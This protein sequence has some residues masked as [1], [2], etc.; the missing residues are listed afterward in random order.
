[1]FSYRIQNLSDC[2]HIIFTYT[3]IYKCIPMYT[4]VRFESFTTFV[5]EQLNVLFEPECKILFSVN[6]NGRK[7]KTHVIYPFVM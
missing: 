5:I 2:I 3:N 6:L 7:R 4:Y 1:M